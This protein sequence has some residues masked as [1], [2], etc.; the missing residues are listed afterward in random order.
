MR[1]LIVTLSVALVTAAPLNRG[2][3]VERMFESWAAKFGKNYSPDELPARIRAFED[4][5]ELVSAHSAQK[6]RSFD[7]MLNR[8]A[9]LS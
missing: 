3:T 9:D 5:L 8:F 7:M 4:N 1:S 6:G 2:A